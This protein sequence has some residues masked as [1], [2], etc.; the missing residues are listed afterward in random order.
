MDRYNDELIMLSKNIWE[1]AEIKWKEY[2]SVEAQKEILKKYGVDRVSLNPQSFQE[3]TLARVHRKFNRRHFEEVYEDCKR[4]GFIL[5]MDFILGLPEETTEDI[6]DTL[7][8]LKQF[9]V[10]NITIHSLAFK[11]ASKLAKGSQER[12]EIDRK[13]IEEKISSLMREKKLE[14][15]YLYR[16]KNMLDW[17]ENIGY[18]KIGT[19]SIFN[20]EMIEENQNTIALGGGGISK[21]VVEEENGHDYIERFVNPKDPALYIREME[22]RQKQKFALFE[23]YRKGK[24]E[25]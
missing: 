23:K 13:K 5:N 4:L 20:M 22:E 11:R 8:Q 9:D 10:E 15:Y 1:F 24:N 14:P 21:V 18:A 16:Q 25:V 2:K 17:G 12:E 6:L 7:E 19:E 3:K